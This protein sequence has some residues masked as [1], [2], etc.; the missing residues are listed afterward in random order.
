[1]QSTVIDSRRS[2]YSTLQ[3]SSL[4]LVAVLPISPDEI[5]I[6]PSLRTP[7]ISTATAQTYS[8]RWGPCIYRDFLFSSTLQAETLGFTA[9]VTSLER[10]NVLLHITSQTGDLLPLN[11][12]RFIPSGRLPSS[13]SKV[14][15]SSWDRK[16]CTLK[17]LLIMLFAAVWRGNRPAL[18]L[19]DKFVLGCLS[20]Q[21]HRST[22][23]HTYTENTHTYTKST[24]S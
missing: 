13:Q 12:K 2:S 11:G 1:M 8:G 17:P 7:D 20:V 5:G 10:E 23:T 16:P 24:K 6:V 14:T 18:R 21:R 9:N 4:N 22:Y 15:S 3:S 19:Q